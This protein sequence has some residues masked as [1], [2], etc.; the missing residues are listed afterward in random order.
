MITDYLS[1]SSSDLSHVLG[2]VL[3]VPNFAEIVMLFNT[4]TSPFKLWGRRQ[5]QILSLRKQY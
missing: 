3:I 1:L 5:T 2:S 4:L